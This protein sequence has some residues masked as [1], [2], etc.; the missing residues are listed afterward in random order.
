MRKLYWIFFSQNSK[1]MCRCMPSLLVCVVFKPF[2][3]SR[4]YYELL[5]KAA[6]II[7]IFSFKWT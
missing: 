7:Y 4:D 2:G 1:N 6:F 5:T 3:T